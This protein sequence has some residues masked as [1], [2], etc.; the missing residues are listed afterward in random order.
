[1]AVVIAG[2]VPGL[3]VEQYEKVNELL[4]VSSAADLEGLICHTA[5]PTENGMYISDVWESQE[6]FDRFINDR[7]MPV[8][9]RLGIDGQTRPTVIEVYRHLHD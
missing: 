1:M 5:G 4:G 8:F 2:E 7:L 6:A 9:E 3:T